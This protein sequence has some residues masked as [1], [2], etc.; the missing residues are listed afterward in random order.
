MPG[1]SQIRRGTGDRKKNERNQL[2]MTAKWLSAKFASCCDANEFSFPI[3]TRPSTNIIPLANRRSR[4][5]LDWPKIEVRSMTSVYFGD[6]VWW[7]RCLAG[8]RIRKVYL[9][10]ETGLISGL[11]KESMVED[12]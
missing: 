4:L 11:T 7:L 6:S 2:W 1:S 5:V 9:P 8:E 3:F 12:T 10:Q